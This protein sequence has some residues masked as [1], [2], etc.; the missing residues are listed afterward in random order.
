MGRSENLGDDI[1]YFQYSGYY[2]WSKLYAVIIK[3]AKKE[4]FKI[5][6]P[7]YKDKA[8]K[9]GVEREVGMYFEKK[10]DQM[11]K[12]SLNF[13]IQMWD[14]V[15]VEIQQNGAVK[16]LERGRFKIGIS[17]KIDSD[18]QGMFDKGFART[19]WKLYA[20]LTRKEYDFITWDELHKKRYELLNEI[21][22]FLDTQTTEG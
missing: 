1:K 18:F 13:S 20:R 19:L 7:L 8:T 11:H 2:D 10:V 12:Y 16:K 4:Q 6:E 21:K 14:C 15:P 3:W 5:Y 17:G 22:T 9:M